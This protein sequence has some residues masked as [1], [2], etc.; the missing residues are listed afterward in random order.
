MQAI[1]RLNVPRQHNGVEHGPTTIIPQRYICAVRKQ[2]L[3][4][5]NGPF[6]EMVKI[7][8][9]EVSELEEGGRTVSIR[10]VRITTSLQ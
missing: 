6:T 8:S 2:Q 4:A 9:P 7:G 3:K 1:N 5:G 10:E